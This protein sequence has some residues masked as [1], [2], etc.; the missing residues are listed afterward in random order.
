MHEEIIKQLKTLR[1]INPDSGFVSRTRRNFS[2]PTSTPS[3]VILLFS[4]KYIG[5]FAMIIIMVFAIPLF[6]MPEQTLASLDSETISKEI[7]T[8][9]IN[10]QLEEIR[11]NDSVQNTISDAI[12]EASNT[13]TSHL[14]TSLLEKEGSSSLQTKNNEIE[15]NV[16]DL[17]NEVIK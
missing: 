12:S 8:L 7:H 2:S 11:Y 13:D 15:K 3:R 6:F 1:E 5:A 4:W 10:V 14:N 17:L 16:D 9:P